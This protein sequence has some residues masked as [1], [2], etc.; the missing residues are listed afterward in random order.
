MITVGLKLTHSVRLHKNP[1]VT[2]MN[3][4]DA[5]R[6][7]QKQDPDALLVKTMIWKVGDLITAIESGD[8]GH[9]FS[10]SIAGDDYSPRG[11]AGLGYHV[12]RPHTLGGEEI[13]F[14]T[15]TPKQLGIIGGS[16]RT[17]AKKKA[18]IENGRKGGRPHFFSQLYNFLDDALTQVHT[19]YPVEKLPPDGPACFSLR[20]AEIVWQIHWQ[21]IDRSVQVFQDGKNVQGYNTV[22]NSAQSL[23]KRLVEDIHRRKLERMPEDYSWA[24]ELTGK[25]F[26]IKEVL[27]DTD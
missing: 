11:I 27:P 25:P 8:S 24:E 23:A 16:M 7:I 10:W 17:E 9:G 22:N 20:C 18:S 21:P 14:S 3:I 26:N 15:P 19:K 4:I 6:E 2:E 13:T 1:R 12:T 5:L